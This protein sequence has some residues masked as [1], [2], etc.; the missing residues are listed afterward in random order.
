MTD[1]IN[2][3]EFCGSDEVYIPDVGI[4]F[5]MAGRDYSFCKKCL[6][7]MTAL[8]FW[9]RIFMRLGYQWPPRIKEN[10]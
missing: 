7:D 8:E 2:S 9:A 10:D 5:G 1:N 4:A 3:C 6:E